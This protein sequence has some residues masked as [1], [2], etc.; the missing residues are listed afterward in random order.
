MRFVVD[1]S[2]WRFD[3]LVLAECV[4]A[5][6]LILDQLDDARAQGHAACYSEDLFNIP[7]WQ[8]QT[9]YDLYCANT[10]FQIPRA[11][12]ER[13]AAIFS[14]L[15]KWQDGDALWPTTFDIQMGDG[16]TEY[17]PSIAWAH[18]QTTESKADAIACI[19]FLNIRPVGACNIAVSGDIACIWM[20]GDKASYCN[21]FRWLIVE[22]TSKPSEMEKL[23]GSAFPSI[24]FAEG[25]F[26]GIKDMSKAYHELVAEIVRHLGCL[27]D[28][29]QRIFLEQRTRVEAEFGALGVNISD[30]NGNTKGDKVAR[31]E[32]TRLIDGV[33]VIFWWHTKLERH[34]D[35][36]HINPDRIRDGGKLIV[37]I[38]CNHLK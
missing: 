16:P 4:E 6:E 19:V 32:R 20:V 1:E 35:R 8:D 30:E 9:F 11:T 36:I 15:P 3:G 14:G 33:E 29:G 5:L 38:F 13:V 27:A 18:K 10:K 31:K 12:Q 23:S 25:A 21:F 37:G 17:A 28:H 34:Q 7:V 2:S 26:S 24:E 22:T